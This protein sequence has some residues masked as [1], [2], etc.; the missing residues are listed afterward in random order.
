MGRHAVRF[1]VTLTV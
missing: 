1:L